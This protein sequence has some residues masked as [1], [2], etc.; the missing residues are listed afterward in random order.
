M[1][2]MIRYLNGL[3]AARKAVSSS[4]L[5]QAVDRLLELLALAAIICSSVG[6]VWLLWG[7]V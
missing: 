7:H 2:F 5:R 4:P 3:P 6:L 1:D